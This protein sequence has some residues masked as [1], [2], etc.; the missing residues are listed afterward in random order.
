[1]RW[2]DNILT[3]RLRLAL[4]GAF[5]LGIGIMPSHAQDPREAKEHFKN[6]NYF[7]AKDVYARL[8]KKNPNNPEF[9]YNLGLCYL[10][11][12]IDKTKAIPYLEKAAKMP[13]VN[14]EV[15]F[16]LGK[17]YSYNYEFDKAIE[18][19]NRYKAANSSGAAK[20]DKAIEDCQT[21]KALMKAPLDVTF[22]NMG[23]KI[24]SEY[25]DYYPYV[26]KDESI[27]VYTTRRKESKGG[28]EFDGYYP[29]DVWMSIRNKETGELAPSKSAG[30]MNTMYDEQAVGLSDDGKTVFVY[31][32]HVDDYGDIYTCE[33][34]SSNKYGRKTK[35][36][37]S[38][39]SKEFETSAS[40]SADGNT[41]FFASAR[42][43]GQG[44]RDLYMARKLPTGD[45]AL[46]QNLGTQINTPKNEDFPTLSF[47]NQTLYFCSEGHKGMGG[48]DLYYS[49]WEPESNTWS[50]PRNLGHPINTPYDDRTISFSE[51]G[52]HAYVSALRKGGV[53]DL[54]IYQVTY[55]EVANQPAIFVVQL[56]S[57][58]GDT[59][60]PFI[61]EGATIIVFDAN[62]EEYGSYFPNPN[63]GK[64]IM[65]LPPGKYKMEIEVEGFDLKTEALE[66]KSFHV[67]MPEI[68]KFITLSQ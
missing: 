53:G 11:T 54:D 48:Y 13:K 27:L 31:I 2:C 56:P 38:V 34:S 68:Q 19:F 57:P 25:P 51:D 24:N 65:A 64:F 14:P 37:E 39:N 61:T 52:M 45:W 36:G 58:S 67:Q 18:A 41:L 46:P 32:D 9:Q 10:R 17:A 16:D 1:M 26:A 63:T 3:L 20:A 4:L 33:M 6:Q 47:D 49:K 44:G 23:P 59:L 28:K 12:N 15:T 40:I 8:I 30:L 35:L 62:E 22:T 66:V 7:A 5:V 50:A 55:N 60:K 29:S 21:A 42:D 43:G